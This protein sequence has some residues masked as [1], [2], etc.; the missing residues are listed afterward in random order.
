M[1]AKLALASLAALGAIFLTSARAQVT[2]QTVEYR[3]G[4]TTLEGYIAYDVSNTARRP[5]VLVVHDWMGVSDHTKEV[6]QELAK[7]GYLAFAADIYGKGVRPADRTLASAEAGKYKADRK[8]L[9][10]RVNAAFKEMKGHAL[11]EPDKT[12]AIGFCFGGTT[13]LELARSGAEVGGVVSFHGS[14]D[15][16]AP[17][18]GKNIK[19]KVLVLHGAEDPFVKKEDIDAFQKELIDAGVDWQM[20]YYGNAVH[21]F[22]QKKAGNDKSKGTAYEEKAA[23]RSWESM[24]DFFNEVFGV[25]K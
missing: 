15:S 23:R 4:D 14:L 18:D 17:A 12:A 21:S 6:A 8:L 10:E 13:V 22:T 19:A 24:K 5:A 25:T 7:L 11:A 2:G 1:K 3:A 16:P 20:V 9:R